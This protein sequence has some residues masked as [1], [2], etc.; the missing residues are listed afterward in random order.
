M[1]NTNTRSFR[2]GLRNR[3]VVDR[4]FHSLFT[5][6]AIIAGAMLVLIF[7]FVAAR[8]VIVFLPSYEYGNLSI[9]KFL[10]GSL[11]RQDQA[12]YGVG[13]IIINTLLVS[14]F[15]AILAFPL[16]VLSALFIVRIAGPR[17]RSA[18]TTVV[19]VLAAIPSV[20]YGVFAAGSI[21]SWVE[22]LAKLFGVTTFGGNSGLTAV[23][24]L[25]L[26]IYPTMTA[27][28]VTSIRAVPASLEHASL[29]LG[30]S[31]TQTNFNVILPAA[32]SGI[33]AGLIL[34]LGRAFGEATAVSMVAGNAMSGPS[35]NP[36]DI[37]RTLTS[38][39]LAGLK[40]TSGLDYDVRF[41]VGIVLM[42]VILIFNA[43]IQRVRKR[44]GGQIHD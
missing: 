13:F 33:I 34:G 30:A 16:S 31:V 25:T 20:V 42:I 17:L 9:V 5:V 38:T 2:K 29:A 10:F 12:I 23:I 11:W 4:L 44:I 6:S 39:I 22:E 7:V 43:L 21:S 8:G 18:M 37:T 14:L 24:L 26:M 32:R 15:A 40:E 35:W 3:R 28:A 19:E 41:S 36:F 27:L 1:D